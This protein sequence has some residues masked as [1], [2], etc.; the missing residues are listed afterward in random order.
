MSEASRGSESKRREFEQHKRDA[1]PDKPLN[2]REAERV[3][4]A[5]HDHRKLTEPR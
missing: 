1:R 3:R 5:L 4:E 2:K